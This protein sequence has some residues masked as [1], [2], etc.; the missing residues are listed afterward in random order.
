[1]YSRSQVAKFKSRYPSRARVSSKR[2]SKIVVRAA[3]DHGQE[4]KYRNETGGS[5]TVILDSTVVGIRH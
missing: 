2:S 1:M 3:V 5:K 4:V